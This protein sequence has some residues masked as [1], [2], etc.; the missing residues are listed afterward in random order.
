MTFTKFIDY[1]RSHPPCVIFLDEIDAIGGKRLD[2]V[3]SSPYCSSLGFFFRS[4]NAKNTYGIIESNGWF[5]RAG[6]GEGHYGHQQTWYSRSCSSQTWYTLWIRESSPFLGRLDRK[7]EIPLP[8]ASGRKSILKIHSAKMTIKGEVG[9]F[10][11]GLN[12]DSFADSRLGYHLQVVR[13]L[14]WCWS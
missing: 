11:M 6:P 7:V 13:W 14:Q 9:M 4:W 10:A 12:V 5:Q 2:N 3:F 1:A 8:T